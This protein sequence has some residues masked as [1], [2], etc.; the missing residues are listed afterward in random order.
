[1]IAN[2]GPLPH[3]PLTGETGIRTNR[4]IFIMSSMT[5]ALISA[6]CIFGGAL[7]GFLLQGLLPEH[8]LR[9]R[10]HRAAH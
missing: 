7:L 1:L 9:D 8:H 3:D 10:D 2:R 5:I 6:G 4:D